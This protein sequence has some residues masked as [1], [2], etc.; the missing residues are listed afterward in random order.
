MSDSPL[1]AEGEPFPVGKDEDAQRRNAVLLSGYEYDKY[2]TATEI[3]RW[4][5]DAGAP[6]EKVRGS[7][8]GINKWFVDGFM[9]GARLERDHPSWLQRYLNVSLKLEDAVGRIPPL[10]RFMEKIVIS[11]RKST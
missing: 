6:V 3:G 5:A 1:K 2:N 10:N 9:I 8:F 7:G 4:L 11:G